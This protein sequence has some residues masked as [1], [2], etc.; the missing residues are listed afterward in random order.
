MS[1]TRFTTLNPIIVTSPDGSHPP[2]QQAWRREY[3]DSLRS[4]RP[5]FIAISDQ[6]IEVFGWIHKSPLEA[7]HGLP[8][9]DSLIMPH[10]R[11][12]TVIGGYTLLKRID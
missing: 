2:F 3:V 9:F 5:Y 1:A 11:Q 7:I 4:A 6:P 12:D 8:G 10:Y